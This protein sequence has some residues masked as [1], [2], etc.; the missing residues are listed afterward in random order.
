M[1]HQDSFD[2]ELGPNLLDIT[3]IQA[4]EVVSIKKKDQ[5]MDQIINLI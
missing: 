4:E 2:Q 1:V 3:H 5:Y